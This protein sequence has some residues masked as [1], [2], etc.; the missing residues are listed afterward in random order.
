[1]WSKIKIKTNTRSQFQLNTQTS[2]LVILYMTM[3][4][5]NY[6]SEAE[7]GL[8]Q[9]IISKSPIFKTNSFKEDKNLII[10]TRNYC[11]SHDNQ[12]KFL[13]DAIELLPDSIK[14]A[15]F[16]LALE[17]VFVDGNVTEEEIAFIESLSAKIGTDSNLVEAAI[18]IFST[19]YLENTEQGQS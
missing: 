16:F 8:M 1:M 17:M 19:I 7:N 15:A 18:E 11:D 5:D 3:K 14:K 13:Q 10:D 2:V 4:A 9:Q 12:D 6:E